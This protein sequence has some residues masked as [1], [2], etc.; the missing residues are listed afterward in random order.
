MA[1][2]IH[3]FYPRI[4]DL[5]NYSQGLRIDTKIY[6]WKTLNNKVLKKL[7]FELNQ[8]TIVA[9]ANSRPGVIENVL[10][11]LRSILHTKKHQEQ[12]SYF[13]DGDDLKLIDNLEIEQ[14]TKDRQLLFQKIQE[15]EEQAQYIQALESKIEK[16][17]QLMKLKDAKIAKLSAKLKK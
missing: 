2:V 13:D 8:E 12:A 7:N 11:E 14:N 3:H 4:V 9:L 6:N 15:C 5:F 17:E 1:E 10:Y 16:L